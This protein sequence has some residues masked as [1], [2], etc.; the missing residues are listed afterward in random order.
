MKLVIKKIDTFSLVKLLAFIQM[1]MGLL[2]GIVIFFLA[3]ENGGPLSAE[4]GAE[5][6]LS[7]RSIV[8]L[9]I[10]YAVAGVVIGFLTGF[11]FNFSARWFGGLII[12]VENFSESNFKT[13]QK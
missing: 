5:F 3:L 13:T 9:P 2:A 8:T 6:F 12:E 1:A 11:V 7:T 4:E 10:L